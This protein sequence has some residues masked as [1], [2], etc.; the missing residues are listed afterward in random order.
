MSGV[1]KW[2]SE[3][4]SFKR[5]VCAFMLYSCINRYLT[6]EIFW[7]LKNSQQWPIDTICMSAMHA[8]GYTQ[9]LFNYIERHIVH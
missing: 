7:V 9:L 5:Q 8:H 3:D 6:L 1:L 4:G 2:A